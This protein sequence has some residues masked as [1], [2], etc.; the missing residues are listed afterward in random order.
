M[1]KAS[2]VV[3]DEELLARR[4]L[5]DAGIEP[6]ALMISHGDLVKAVEKA[7]EFGRHFGVA[8]VTDDDACRICG[9]T[10]YRACLGGCSWAEPDLCSECAIPDGGAS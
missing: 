10:E 9:C 5:N 6:G 2:P 1:L 7:W 3:Q 4:V 8:E